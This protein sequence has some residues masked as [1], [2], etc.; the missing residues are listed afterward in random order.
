[1]NK[2]CFFSE[3]YNETQKMIMKKTHGMIENP[4]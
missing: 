2:R 4:N 1:M 3:K